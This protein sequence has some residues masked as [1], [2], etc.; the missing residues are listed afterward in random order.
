MFKAFKEA[1]E[2]NKIRFIIDVTTATVIM[3]GGYV[4]LH[5]VLTV[6]G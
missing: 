6:F 5:F 1:W 2:E 3:V 4:T